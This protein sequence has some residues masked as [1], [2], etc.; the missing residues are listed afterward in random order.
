LLFEADF[1]NN[2]K[3]IGRALMYQAE[4]VQL[5]AE[6]QFGSQ[7]FKLAIYQCLNKQL[8]CNLIRFS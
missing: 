1:N 5:L 2:N 7:K 3:W 6:E 4:Q 8:F